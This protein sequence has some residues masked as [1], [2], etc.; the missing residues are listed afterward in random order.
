MWYVWGR[1]KELFT[2]VRL[3]NLKEKDHF[4]PLRVKRIILKRMLK[5]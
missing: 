1:G 2:H 5:K 3:E 4:K